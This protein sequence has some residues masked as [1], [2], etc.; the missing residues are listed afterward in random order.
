MALVEHLLL[1]VDLRGEPLDERVIATDIAVRG[2]DR[3]RRSSSRPPLQLDL[4]TQRGPSQEQ[5]EQ[6]RES[7]PELRPLWFSTDITTIPPPQGHAV[8]A[9][10]QALMHV[11][12]GEQRFDLLWLDDRGQ[13]L[14]RLDARAYKSWVLDFQGVWQ[15]HARRLAERQARSIFAGDDV[16]IERRVALLFDELAARFEPGA[17]TLAPRLAP[18]VEDVELS[19]AMRRLALLSSVLP[20]AAEPV[21]REMELSWYWVVEPCGQYRWCGVVG[22]DHQQLLAF[23]LI[24]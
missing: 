18:Q 24:G 22:F 16:V 10:E 2:L 19:T 5:R 23:G 11:D 12:G 8:F 7:L 21:L 14:A 13:F 3:W 4:W 9:L 17:A 15:V 20:R 1:R 6:L